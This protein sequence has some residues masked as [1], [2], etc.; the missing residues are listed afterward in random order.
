MN[1]VA[2]ANYRFVAPEPATPVSAGDTP[3]NEGQALHAAGIDDS[4]S[5]DASAAPRHDPRA[6]SNA[7]E[8]TPGDTA[9][10]N[11]AQAVVNHAHPGKMPFVGKPAEMDEVARLKA[12]V[13]ELEAE[14]ARL[15]A[16]NIRL[17]AEVVNLRN[18]AQLPDVKPPTPERML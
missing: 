5:P 11:R 12:R 13:A 15:V 9:Y 8:W 10:F 4:T 6:V 16:E 14:N 1:R 18:L 7:G 17:R 3:S 2:F